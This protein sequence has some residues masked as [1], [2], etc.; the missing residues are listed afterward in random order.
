MRLVFC[1]ICSHE[2]LYAAPQLERRSKGGKI[3][4]WGD[5]IGLYFSNFLELISKKNK[6]IAAK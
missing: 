4:L 6:V 2:K 3:S 5:Q 1:E